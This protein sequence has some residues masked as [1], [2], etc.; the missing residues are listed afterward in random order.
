MERLRIKYN[1]ITELYNAKELRKEVYEAMK[2][3]IIEEL[4]IQRQRAKKR[5]LNLDSFILMLEQ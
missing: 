4:V 3:E 1:V 2:Q 5:V